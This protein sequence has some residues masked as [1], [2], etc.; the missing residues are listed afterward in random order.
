MPYA[1]G[2][3]IGIAQKERYRSNKQRKYYILKR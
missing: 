3:P 1:G 2:E